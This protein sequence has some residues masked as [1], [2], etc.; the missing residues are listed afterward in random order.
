MIA[1]TVGEGSD[2]VFVDSEGIMSEIAAEGVLWTGLSFGSSPI[3]ITSN[4]G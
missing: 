1:V 2:D 3:E 4:Q